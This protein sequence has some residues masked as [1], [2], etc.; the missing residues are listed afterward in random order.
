MSIEIIPINGNAFA[1]EVVGAQLWRDLD[2]AEFETIQA[3]WATTTARPSA[4][5]APTISTG[6]P[7][8][9]MYSSRLPAPFSTAS[10]VGA[11]AVVDDDLLAEAFGKFLRD[12]AA[13]D[14]VAAAGG[15]RHDHAQGPRR[16]TLRHD[17]DT[18]QAQAK[19]N[20]QGCQRAQVRRSSSRHV[21]HV[22]HR[23]GRLKRPMRPGAAERPRPRGY[24]Q[25]RCLRARE[26]APPR[27]R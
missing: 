5:P 24:A 15:K 7:T 20:R 11:G 6:T 3:A 26:S 4:A 2:P 21:L 14:I 16:K 25:V 1:R 9:R 8:S 23:H 13:E 17:T 27:V 10:K 18:V 12:E 19:G 22:R